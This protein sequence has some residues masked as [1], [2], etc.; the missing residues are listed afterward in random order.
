[1][2]IGAMQEEVDSVISGAAYLFHLPE[3]DKWVFE[4]KFIP[5]G[6]RNHDYFGMAV[7]I[8]KEVVVVG[9]PK[10]DIDKLKRN[11][12]MGSADVYSLSD[13]GWIAA[14]KIIPHD[15][16]SEDHFGMAISSFENTLLIGS[17]LNDNN[18]FN[19]GSVYFYKFSE[20]FPA[21]SP[22]FIPESF[23]L[24]QNFPNPF[25]ALTTIRYNLPMDT[26][27]NITIYDILGRKIIELVNGEEVAGRKQII[28]TGNN[29]NGRPSSS[30]V[31]IYRLETTK[32][33]YT[34][35][36]ILMK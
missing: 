36:M 11:G 21:L 8:N 25:N 35:K 9:S 17:R 23:E 4:K 15:G 2:L 6:K 1:L 14:G 24:Y 33:N 10:W 16:A 7:Y 27:V 19:N 29:T 26:R 3:D 13:S 32:F 22:K 30:G 18:A 28:W 20:L 34:K 12:D 31:Y 5:D